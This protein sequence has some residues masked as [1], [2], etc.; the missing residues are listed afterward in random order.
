VPTCTFK[1]PSIF[2]NLTPGSIPLN[3]VCE[4]FKT[5]YVLYDGACGFCRRTARLV[6]YFDWLGKVISRDLVREWPAL[7]T[8]FPSLQMDACLK[9]MHVIRADGQITRG[10]DA[11]RS[12]VWVLPAMWLILPLLYLPPVRWLGRKIYR[13]I[14]DN[15]RRT[16]AVDAK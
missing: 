2:D 3:I 4:R 14:A 11:Y 8:E 9:D 1:I 10:F 7:Q 5:R 13:H 16:C 15:R 12:L 6:P